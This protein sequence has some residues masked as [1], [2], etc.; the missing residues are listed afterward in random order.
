MVLDEERWPNSPQPCSCW[1]WRTERKQEVRKQ[2]VML[3]QCIFSVL[4]LDLATAIA[5]V[6]ALRPFDGGDGDGGRGRPGTTSGATDAT[7]IN[8]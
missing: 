5:F 3:T 7:S 1:A 6:V 2:E 4:K 8:L